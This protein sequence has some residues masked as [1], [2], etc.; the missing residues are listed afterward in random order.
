VLLYGSLPAYRE[1]ASG[2]TGPDVRQFEQNLYDLG[3]RGFTVDQTYSSSTAHAVG[4]WQ[5]DLGL[6][7]TG[8][9][10]LGQVVYATDAVRVDSL[11]AAV[12]DD[13]QPGADVLAYTGMTR[14]VTVEL[15]VSDQR[16]A[17]KDA[18]VMVTLPDG[19]TVLGKITNTA[20]VIDATD[21]DS[22]AGDDIETT[23]EVS[24]TADDPQALAGLE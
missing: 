9:V 14:V 17:T 3:Y 19:K 2:V 4:E 16:L 18:A 15:D 8:T 5:E 6:T 22:G 1:L 23:I 12:G 10:G 7:E 11:D 21:T 13:A 20:T 24:V